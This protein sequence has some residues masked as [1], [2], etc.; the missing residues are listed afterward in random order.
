MKKILA[1]LA[2]LAFCS[3]VT[4]NADELTLTTTT[5]SVYL[6]TTNRANVYQVD[7]SSDKQVSFQLFDCDSLADPYFGTN[8]VNAAYVYRISY[9]SNIATSF[10]GNNGYTNWYTN[11]VMYMAKLT[12]SASTNALTP[13][14]SGS[15][16]AN[17]HVTYNVDAL[18]I[19][20]I[21]AAVTTNAAIVLEYRSSQ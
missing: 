2:G 14:I 7:I 4:V 20:G 9:P 21:S 19:R 10:V 5:N 6:I 12:N 3:I 17:G 15:C 11:S 1:L 18:F 16:A 13:L 8:Y